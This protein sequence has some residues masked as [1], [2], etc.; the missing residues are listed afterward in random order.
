MLIR[1]ARL[2]EDKPALL[3]FID[4]S[5]KFEHAIEPDRRIDDKVAEEFLF[6]IFG[7]LAAKGGVALV[8]EEAGQLLGWS[9]VYRDENELYVR[10]EERA[11]AL[12]SELFVVEPAR[13]RGIGQSLIAACEQWARLHG[14]NVVMINVLAAN[15]RAHSIY[16][17]SGFDPYYVGLRKYLR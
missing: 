10:P 1:A 14:L 13:G 7:R 6:E 12:I 15:G 5:Q 8:A 17:E 2:P 4:G 11:F 9:V 16:R 3:S